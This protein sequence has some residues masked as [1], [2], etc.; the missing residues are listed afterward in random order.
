ML[1]ILSCEVVV[2]KL[3][4]LGSVQLW[5]GLSPTENLQIT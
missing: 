5:E 2:I 4:L 3:V 1:E